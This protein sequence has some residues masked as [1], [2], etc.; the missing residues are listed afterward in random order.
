MIKVERSQISNLSP[1]PK[2]L[3]EQEQSKLIISRR[4]EI[5]RITVEVNEMRLEKLI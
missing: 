5:I 3:E 1:H 2:E 4:K